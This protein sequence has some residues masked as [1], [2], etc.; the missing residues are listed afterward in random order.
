V[1]QLLIPFIRIFDLF[2]EWEQKDSMFDYICIISAHDITYS[3]GV[4]HSSAWVTRRAREQK[5]L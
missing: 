2:F 5:M 1:I 3:V 4:E